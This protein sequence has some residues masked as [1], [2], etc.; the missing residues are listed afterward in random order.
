MP[1][2]FNLL[3]D[4]FGIETDV[5]AQY[6]RAS[7]RK[8]SFVRPSF[9]RTISE[10]EKKYKV[11]LTGFSY[12]REHDS[13][14]HTTKVADR[15]RNRKYFICIMMGGRLYLEEFNPYDFFEDSV[16]VIVGL[17]SSSIVLPAFRLREIFMYIPVKDYEFGDNRCCIDKD[18]FR[19]GVREYLAHRKES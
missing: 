17:G 1:K 10:V 11:K 16:Y 15:N 3:N 12:I 2:S 9:K 18:V 8:M 14:S 19:A 13:I 4:W 5:V 7:E 6:H